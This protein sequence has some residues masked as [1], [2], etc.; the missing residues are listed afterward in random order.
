MTYA[1]KEVSRAS[2]RIAELYEFRMDTADQ[3]AQGEPAPFGDVIY[4]ES[5]SYGATADVYSPPET[6]AW[7]AT[8]VGMLAAGAPVGGTAGT[9]T[10]Q[11]LYFGGGIG[12]GHGA[13]YH[14]HVLTGLDPACLYRI[15]VRMVRNQTTGFLLS[16]IMVALGYET[17]IVYASG[18]DCWLID[19]FRPGPSG[20]VPI[21][22][23]QFDLEYGSFVAT[24]LNIT[25]YPIVIG[26]DCETV[27]T[28]PVPN[29]A[30][31]R[32]Y[33]SADAA[34]V[35]QGVTYT[36]AE[37]KRLTEF[38][39]PQDGVAKTELDL[40]IQ[41]DEPI[42]DWFNRSELPIAPINCRI[43]RVHRNDL[44]SDAKPFVGQAIRVKL[45]GNEA[46]LTLGPA[47]RAVERKTPRTLIQ[48][49]CNNMLY[50][51]R[52]G[53]D[54]SAFTFAGTV[55]DIPDAGQGALIEIIG[56]AA[57]MAG[58]LSYFNQG[59]FVSPSGR[60]T[61]ILNVNPITELVLLIR[62]PRDVAIGD[63]VRLFAG[64]DRSVGIC[65]HR[66]NNLERRRGWDTI[67]SKNPFVGSGLA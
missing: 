10:M 11:G 26:R 5:W 38:G 19:Y 54:P 27:G 42:C 41:R 55:T 14:T 46:I 51:L 20:E 36:K 50:D 21:S 52:C 56:I 66:F 31:I 47:E 62:A 32:N 65:F 49:Q 8:N 63:Q 15:A 28:P 59:V 18:L 16:G 22:F 43:L 58:D 44:A 48:P 24:P 3:G 35:Y 9:F 1:A 30:L 13:V 37:I 6:A 45:Q 23:G 29:R 4:T 40:S 17:H 67:P 60:R 39:N 57:A 12:D 64:C 61:S 53:V 2:G 34:V 25:V 7:P 33:T